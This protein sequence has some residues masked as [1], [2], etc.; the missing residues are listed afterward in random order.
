M[1]IFCIDLLQ[2][3]YC[4][5]EKT[6]NK[7]KRGRIG[8]FFK[9]RRDQEEAAASSSICIKRPSFGSLKSP[10]L[11]LLTY[12]QSGRTAVWHD[13]AFL[14]GLG[15]T[16]SYQRRQNFPWLFGLFVNCHY[17][18]KHYCGYFVGHFWKLGYFYSII[19]SHWFLGASNLVACK[20]FPEFLK[21]WKES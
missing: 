9:K 6:E 5:F 21:E 16:F 10:I 14:K 13:W 2:K 17:V 3:L 20:F 7:R 8:P 4:L 12:L 18:R 15:V 1:D 11:P 19:R